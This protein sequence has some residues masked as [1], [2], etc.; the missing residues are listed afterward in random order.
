MPR[1]VRA[2]LLTALAGTAL[3]AS[4]EAAKPATV[5]IL[6]TGGTIAG[7]QPAAGNTYYRPALSAEDLVRSV[8]GL[9]ELAD[10]HTE[11]IANIGSETMSH[12]IW[13]KLATR[14]ET[15]LAGDEADGVVVTHGT[16]TLEETA[17]FLSLVVH[18]D[19]P[20]VLVGAMRPASANGADGP[21]NLYNAVAL[22]ADPRT[23]GRGPLVV[24]NDEIHYA[25]EATKTNTLR[26]DAFESPNRGRAGVIHAGEVRFFNSNTARHSVRSEFS[27]EGLSEQELPDVAIV[28]SHAGYGDGVIRH[29]V[30][31]GVDG[32]VLAG[33]GAGNTTDAARAA[34]SEAVSEGVA[35]VRSSRVGSGLVERSSSPDDPASDA[36]LG[37][38]AA[39]ELNPQKARILL[40]LGLTRTRDAAV[41]QRFFDEY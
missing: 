9:G 37:F 5:Y 1:C 28:Y 40:M 11:Q 17:Y 3:W 2:I 15:L 6:A 8:P 4:A 39:Q 19:K 20:V 13:L 32:I 25:R 24:I 10:I 14:I 22:A 23:S 16:D 26:P 41:L 18:S 35:V 36:R 27:L 34:L 29:L 7:S 31:G 33:V 30:E 21:A 12:D 38:I